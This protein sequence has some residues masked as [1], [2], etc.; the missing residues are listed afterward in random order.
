ML[1]KFLL[2]GC[3]L[4]TMVARAQDISGTWT[5]NYG[6]IPLNPSP[7]KLVVE[8]FLYQDS[9]ITGATHL[10]YKKNH[11]E[12][13][14]IKGVYHR[15]D[16]SIY[17]TEDSTIAVKLGFMA[18][19]CLGNYQMKLTVT[20]STMQWNG[21]WSDKSRALFHCP[22][23]RVWLSKPHPK[24]AQP[25]LE[26]ASV[27]SVVEDDKLLARKPDIQSLIEIGKMEMDSIKIELYDN[28]TIDQDSVSLYY[29]QSL[30]VNKKMISTKPITLYISIPA[31]ETVGKLKL[32]AENLGSIPPCTALMIVTTRKKRHEVT[33]S[34]NFDSNAVVE[35]F[36]K[37]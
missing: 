12:H 16:S 3:L 36:I 6:K 29:N 27:P 11:Y 20:D 37:E 14:K 8:L 31:H 18:T 23:T 1:N 21:K 2:L 19:N 33:L 34:S 10:Y 25:A 32:I 15:S 28:G 4:I 30:L 24:P 35:F 17:F 9:L 13:Y 26:N 7:E 5:G 22:S